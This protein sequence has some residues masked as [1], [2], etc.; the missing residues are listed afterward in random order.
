MKGEINKKGKIMK[1]GKALYLHFFMNERRERSSVYMK[2]DE[3]IM[4][5]YS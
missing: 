1:K 2:E 3:G 5:Y 4:C